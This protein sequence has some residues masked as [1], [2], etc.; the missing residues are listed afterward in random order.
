MKKSSSIN[1]FYY[2]LLLW[3]NFLIKKFMELPLGN[4][5][6]VNFL[7]IC[8]SIFYCI[9][10]E[11][12]F[13]FWSWFLI[14]S[15]DV[16]VC[17]SLDKSIVSLIGSDTC[18]EWKIILHPWFFL[19]INKNFLSLYLGILRCKSWVKLKNGD[20]RWS[21]NASLLVPIYEDYGS[22]PI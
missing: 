8:V 16:L 17:M 22:L 9:A 13:Q 6:S 19:I 14:S 4:K 3:W 11:E 18:F 10:F 2:V 21:Q 7:K 20:E 12:I 1:P 5:N 15:R